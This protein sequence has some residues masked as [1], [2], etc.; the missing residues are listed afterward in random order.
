MLHRPAVVIISAPVKPILNHILVSDIGEVRQLPCGSLVMPVAPGHQG[1]DSDSVGDLE[2]EAQGALARLQALVPGVSLCLAETILAE[3]P[4]PGDGLP[5]VGAV[6]EGAYLAVMHSGITLG[7][8]MGELIA[9]ELLQG[10]T[11]H[12]RVWLSPYR[13]GRFS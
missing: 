3:R 12:S 8:V 11:N 13:P 9:G 4:M 7:A 5:A 10:E 2:E 1:D 6:A